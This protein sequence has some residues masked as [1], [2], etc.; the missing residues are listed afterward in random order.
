MLKGIIIGILIY[1]FI[2]TIVTFYKDSSSYFI[3]EILDIIIAGPV[4][5]ILCLIFFLISP[6]INSISKTKKEYVPKSDKYITKIVKKIIKNYKKNLKYTE[7]INFNLYSGEFN[8]NDIE[9][10]KRLLVTKA[11]NEWVNKKFETLMFKQKESVLPFLTPY[12]ILM[13]E[14]ELI[15]DDCDAFFIKNVIENNIQIYKLKT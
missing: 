6:L 10:W 15:K 2:L 14:E 7:Y 9:G 5:W 13:T 1:S 8:V 3:V 4:C 12:F 11:S